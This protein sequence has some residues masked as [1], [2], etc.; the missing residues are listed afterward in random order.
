MN[1]LFFAVGIGV[2]LGVFE[3]LENNQKDASCS[4]LSA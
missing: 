3:Y 2:V 4:L 1:T